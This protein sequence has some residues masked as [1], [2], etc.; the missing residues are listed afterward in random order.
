M[1]YI[2]N[3]ENCQREKKKK[4]EK[5]CK[6]WL[7]IK[8]LKAIKT[9]NVNKNK[10]KIWEDM[11]TPQGKKKRKKKQ[12]TFLPANISWKIINLHKLRLLQ[13]IYNTYVTCFCVFLSYAI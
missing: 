5:H 4:W 12:S 2:D 11:R 6:H 3:F 9:Q 8:H 10:Q 1:N 13:Y 7:K